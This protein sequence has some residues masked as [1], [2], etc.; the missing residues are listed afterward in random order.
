MEECKLDLY[1]LENAISYSR[2]NETH[3]DTDRSPQ[4]HWDSN[5]AV[6]PQCYPLPPCCGFVRNGFIWDACHAT[7][8]YLLSQYPDKNKRWMWLTMWTTL[9]F[10]FSFIQNRIMSVNQPI[11]IPLLLPHSTLMAK[12][13]LIVQLPFS[14]SLPIVQ[15]MFHILPLL[16]HS[17]FW[18]AK[19]SRGYTIRRWLFRLLSHRNYIAC[20]L[21]SPSL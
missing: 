4:S 16:W 21:Y 13:P 10:F 18:V 20:L 9:I 15:D 3:T 8:I 1:P 12:D 11:S 17:T 5:R 2:W 14:I 7:C 19:T 6:R